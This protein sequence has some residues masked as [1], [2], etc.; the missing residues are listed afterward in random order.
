MDPT[1]RVPADEWEHPELEHNELTEWN[2]MVAYPEGLS[3]GMADIGAFTYIN[4]RK[5]VTIE[6]DAQVGSHCAIYS[7]SSIDD[8]H[9]E[10]YIEE[11]ARVGTHSTVM[12]GVTI[13]ESAIVGAH[14]L[15]LDDVPAGA[16]AYGVPAEVRR[17]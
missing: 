14:S 10:V 13:G 8:K 16:T 6:D 2:W 17:T 15:V 11:G 3:L 1:E 12:P 4:A 7:S 5:G 9:G